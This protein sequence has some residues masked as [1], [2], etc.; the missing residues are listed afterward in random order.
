MQSTVS[1]LLVPLLAIIFVSGDASMRLRS[2]FLATPQTTSPPPSSTWATYTF[3]GEEFSV[4]LPEMP[5]LDHSHR[6]VVG[7]MWGETA[8]N[9]GAYGDG[10]VYLIRAYDKPR[11]GE[12]L[13]HFARYFMSPYIHSERTFQLQPTREIRIGKF[14]G[15]QYAIVG[16]TR[17][18]SM[19]DSMPD[20]SIQVFLTEK[21]AYVLR[22]FGGD[23]KHPGVRRFFN[24]FVLSNKPAGRQIVDES[25]LSPPAVEY[26]RP[27]PAP[28]TESGA[29]G[30]EPKNKE[31]GGGSIAAAAATRNDSNVAVQIFRGKEVT[32]K[33]GIVSKPEPAYTEKARKNNVTGTVRLRLVAAA[34]GKITNIVA[35]TRLPNGLTEKAVLAAS[36]IK[37]IPAMK[38]GRLVSQYITIEYNFNIY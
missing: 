11:N 8:R 12:D 24:S 25:K 5:A 36:H 34:S 33:A 21:H 6:D 30:K 17:P 10:I 31:P 29:T 13:D 18:P 4:E 22:A 14:Q 9:Y 23:D 16:D 15:K 19:P 7:E 1:L 26:S 35:I 2:K 27:V 32:R 28:K 37:F 3:K 38:D 20:S